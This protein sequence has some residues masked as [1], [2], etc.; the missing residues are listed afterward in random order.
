MF[1]T[2]HCFSLSTRGG[3]QSGAPHILLRHLSSKSLR[4]FV[5][6]R[7]ADPPKDGQGLQRRES[8]SKLHNAARA[9]RR[10]LSGKNIP[11]KYKNTDVEGSS[12][13]PKRSQSMDKIKRRSITSSTLV[14]DQK[15]S[16]VDERLGRRDKRSHSF[17][18]GKSDAK[19]LAKV[20][21]MMRREEKSEVD[22]KKRQSL[23]VGLMRRKRD[24]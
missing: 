2:L 11:N 16:L 22:P 6:F 5:Y 12:D 24:K 13:P 18:G 9:L 15:N 14:I 23:D 1:L 3:A 19:K 4:N 20:A 10:S 17:H 21:N 7:S 8:T